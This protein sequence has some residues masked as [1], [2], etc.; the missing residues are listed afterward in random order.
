MKL[1]FVNKG[2]EQLKPENEEKKRWGDL[3]EKETIN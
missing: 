2:A 3:G 1:Q